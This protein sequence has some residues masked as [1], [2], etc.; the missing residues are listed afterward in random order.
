MSFI[1][2]FKKKA[3]TLYDEYD[4]TPSTLVAINKDFVSLLFFGQKFIRVYENR[5]GTKLFV[6]DSFLIDINYPKNLINFTNSSPEWGSIYLSDK[7]ETAILDGLQKI[8]FHCYT[9]L[10]ENNFGCCSRFN[11][12]SDYKKCVHKNKL[13][14]YG[15]LYRRNLESG[16]IF[17]GKNRNID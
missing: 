1:E 7:L 13:F 9:L 17:Y 12:C 10:P 16:K 11:E 8:F 14:A 4:C 2:K 15:C 5:N 6:K 3:L